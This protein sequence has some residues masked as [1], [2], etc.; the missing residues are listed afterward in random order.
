M[1]RLIRS[2]WIICVLGSWALLG[3][4]GRFAGPRAEKQFTKPRDVAFVARDG[5]PQHY[6]EM[7]PESFK[8]RRVHNL[9]IALHGMGSDRWQYVTNPC[10]ECRG[11]RD[12]ALKY[13][14]IYISPDYRAPASWLSLQAEND[15]LQIITDLK[16]KYRIGKIYLAGGSMG[17]TSVLIFTIRHPELISGVVSQ[18]GMANMLEYEN[19]KDIITLA[20]GGSKKE[21]PAFYRERSAEYYPERFTMPIAFTTGGRDTVVPPQSVLRLVK[22]IQKFNPRVLLLHRPQ[23]GHSTNYEDT[24]AALEFVLNR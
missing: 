2:R 4:A 8:S 19:F 10:D 20:Y 7:L 5:S 22:S 9:M 13:G 23:A 17:G 11:T 16:A 14:M 15:L 18:N 6:V 24:R 21:K 3:C 1:S 12:M